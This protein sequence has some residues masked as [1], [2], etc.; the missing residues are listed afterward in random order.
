MVLTIASCLGP[1]KLRTVCEHTIN[2][3]PFAHR[4]FK[5]KDNSVS[6]GHDLR[7]ELQDKNTEL[8]DSQFLYLVCMY[9]YIIYGIT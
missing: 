6:V 5:R 7:R 9:A 4:Q 3:T 1:A 2:H 8:I